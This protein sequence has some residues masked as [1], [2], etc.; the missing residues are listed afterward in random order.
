M[1]STGRQPKRG[2]V[3]RARR[4]WAAM[5]LFGRI[6]TAVIAAV[7]G[8][9]VLFLALGGILSAC[10]AG[11]DEPQM[12]VPSSTPAVSSEPATSDGPTRTP[13]PT[14]D[15]TAVETP[16]ESVPSSPAVTP[17]SRPAESDTTVTEPGR[18]ETTA[19]PSREEPPPTADVYYENCD[20]ARDAGAA[21]VYQGDPGYGP[22]L[23]RDGDGVAC[24]PYFGQ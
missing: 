4:R 19:E 10:G 13:T 18:E 2:R 3:W 14:G 8:L 17:P 24:E 11:E 22:H 15:V 5:G 6:V 16:S 1:A 23:D 12:P 21:P 20:A 7:V 9:L